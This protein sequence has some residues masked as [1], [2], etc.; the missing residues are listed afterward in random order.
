MNCGVVRSLLVVLMSFYLHAHS[1][2]KRPLL[3][4]CMRRS[5]HRYS[6]TDG[7]AIVQKPKA[8]FVL[9]GSAYLKYVSV[10]G[11]DVPLIDTGP[12]CGKGTQCEKL[13]AEFGIVHLSAG[14]LLRQEI[15][16]G[17]ENGRIIDDYL[18]KGQIVPVKMSLSLLKEAMRSRPCPRYLID[19]F[20]R[21]KDNLQG[22]ET[23]MNGVCEVDLVLFIE[24]KQSELERRILFRGNSSGRSDD[25]VETV[26]KR[27]QTFERDTM[28]IVEHFMRQP[29]SL[30]VSVDGEQSVEKVYAHVRAIIAEKIEEDT[31]H[32]GIRAAEF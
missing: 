16:K 14:E 17:S 12:G 27:F 15:T 26:R 24:C 28:P 20:P 29:K 7:R 5:G 8:V 21:N 13:A 3:A 10:F 32:T 30:V 19:G 18:K 9:G 31:A 23:E 25:N 6:N 2:L 1:Y 22:W 4:N 11:V